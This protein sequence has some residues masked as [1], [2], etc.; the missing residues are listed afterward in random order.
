MMNF[1]SFGKK[2]KPEAKERR[3][4][5]PIP[6][7]S[8]LAPEE[9]V[10]IEQHSR[11]VGFKRGD[12][13]YEEGAVP[14]AFY[15]IISGRFR[16]FTRA[17]GPEKESTLLY[18]YRG[19][20]FGETSL[21]TGSVHS[22]SVEAK[23][24]AVAL[25]ISAESFQK[26]LHEIPALALH[27]SRSL[28]RHLTREEFG[29]S[30]HRREVRIAAFYFA[31][32]TEGMARFLADFIK[33]LRH[34]TQSKV[35]L[36][37]L[38]GKLRSLL[39]A[40]FRRGDASGFDLKT[41]DPSSES[42]VQK[43]IQARAESFDFLPFL[44]NTALEEEEQKF[45]ALLTF[46]T[47]R[48][49][50]LVICLPDRNT[51]VAVKALNYSDRVYL[52]AEKRTDV[53][54]FASK[55]V[56]E[57]CQDFG[58]NRN[59][60][61]IILPSQEGRTIS[62]Q[63][64]EATA[65]I[66]LFSTL[67]SLQ[68]QRYQYEKTLN[69]LAKEWSERL[70]GLVLGSGAA[71]GLSHIGVLRVLEQE[72]IPVDVIAGSSI[73]A[74]IGALWAAGYDSNEIEKIAKS[75]EKKNA[76]F[77]LLGFRDLSAVHRGFFKGDQITRFLSD[78]LKDMTFQ[79]LKV[80]VK[81]VATDLLTS[82]EIVLDSGSVINAVRASISIPGFFRPYPYKGSYLIDGGIVDPL[83]VKIL[84]N[85]GVRKIIA[86]NVLPAPKDLIERNELRR[87]AFHQ[88]FQ[89]RGYWSRMIMKTLDRIQRRY[90][91]NI[92]NVLMN[93]I[94]FTEFEIAR[95]EGS[96]ADIFI[97]AS[98]PN[99]HWIEFFSADKFI[100]EGVKKTREQLADIRQ[101]LLE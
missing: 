92:F 21:L 67:P 9:Q 30:H 43:A 94:M 89:Q 15:I 78:Y 56:G 19:E 8:S 51:P 23:T 88:S 90:T 61:K 54:T 86:V 36:M 81:M 96:E 85:M 18:F 65:E 87:N 48:Y 77:K 73:G 24:D 12:I 75:V 44:A 58:F 69:F 26:L 93:T 6:L 60:I 70:V 13:V 16:L 41:M 79:D 64:S 28:G 1:F 74:L 33:T 101:L 91:S 10:L 98:V 7:F 32:S 57:L 80:P 34:E 5:D 63:G 62:S 17:R 76:F 59:E 84:S 29:Y 49:D 3:L 83:P 45:T 2:A 46:L 53:F 97:H 47:Y 71:Y 72:K 27:L 82:E 50:Y 11:L 35:L 14:D 68:Y 52:W 40:E 100:N 22:A 55:K 42:S 39:P 20:H 95:M 31:A 25:K 99:A 4:L 38:S 37:D 66:Q